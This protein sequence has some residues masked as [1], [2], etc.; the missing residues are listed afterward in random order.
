MAG[1]P[2][3]VVTDEPNDVTFDSSSADTDRHIQNCDSARLPGIGGGYD[4]RDG[5]IPTIDPD[6]PGRE[7]IEI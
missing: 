4:G 6:G 7:I 3:Y 2:V 5:N 1:F